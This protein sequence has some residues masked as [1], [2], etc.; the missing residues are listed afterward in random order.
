EGLVDRDGLWVLALPLP[1]EAKDAGERLRAHDVGV[2][3]GDDLHRDR[4][5]RLLQVLA[6][7]ELAAVHAE[8]RFG[9]LA[10]EVVSEGERQAEL[11]SRLGAVA[12]RAEQPELRPI[13]GTGNGGDG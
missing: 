13:A 9:V 4:C 11:P 12:A 3:I 6:R 1:D 5:V 8:R 10:R 7:P 2:F